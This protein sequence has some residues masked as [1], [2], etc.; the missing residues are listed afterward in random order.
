MSDERLLTISTFARA[1][2]IPGSALRFYAAEGVLVPAEVDSFTG[3]RY[4]A[5]S[6]IEAGVLVA[7]MRAAGVAVP[8]MRDFLDASA[9]EATRII[10][11]MIAAHSAQSHRRGLELAALRESILEAE[12]TPQAA[13]ATLPG[14][15][16]ASAIDQV[17]AAT[18]AASDDVSGLVWALQD[19]RL[20]LIATDRY[21]LAYRELRPRES[22]GAARV[23]T[24]PEAAAAAASACAQRAEIVLEI[25]ESR[26]RLLDAYGTVMAETRSVERSVPDL[27]LLIST[28]PPTRTIAG[29]ASLALK[30][31]L[32]GPSADDHVLIDAHRREIVGNDEHRL[33]GWVSTASRESGALRIQMQSALLASAVSIC[34]GPEI[35]LGLVDES[36]PVRVQSPLQ[37][38]MTCLVMPMRP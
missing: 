30:D 5:P 14:T 37:D 21:W 2:G 34:Q 28:Q 18:S 32:Q 31:F 33:Q 20:E 7:R 24:T 25:V 8:L 22:D 26:L 23:M 11:R 4:Y 10:D 3:Y 13:R 38:A 36:T 6:Q 35:L 1:V 15:V 29:F 19:G 12:R 9:P 17:A 27:S 16:L